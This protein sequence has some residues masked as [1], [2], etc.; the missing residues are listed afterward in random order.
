VIDCDC[1]LGQNSVAVTK[2]ATAGIEPLRTKK[3]GKLDAEL[4]GRCLIDKGPAISG[5]GS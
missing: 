5:S 2:S 3:A 1:W 4:A